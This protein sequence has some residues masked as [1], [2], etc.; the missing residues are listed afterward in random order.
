MRKNEDF[1]EPSLGLHGRHYFF[2]PPVPSQHLP[3]H[4]LSGSTLREEIMNPARS[5]LESIGRKS[6]WN[7]L[8]KIL[9]HLNRFLTPENLWLSTSFKIITKAF[10]LPRKIF[11]PIP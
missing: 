6:P 7:G 2:L 8:E 1:P 10:G 3:P 4:I 5:D 11:P 9:R